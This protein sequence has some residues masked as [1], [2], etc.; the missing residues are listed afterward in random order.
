[1]DRRRRGILYSRPTLARTAATSAER[2]VPEI[3]RVRSTTSKP[4]NSAWGSI[5]HSSYHALQ[6]KFR[7]RYGGGLQFLVAY[8]WSKAIDDV[9]SVA[10]SWATRIPATRTT[11]GAIS[12]G[13]FR[14]STSRT[15]WR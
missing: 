4:L 14:R 12:T 15:C 6:T 10:G 13:R 1:M 8:T 2:A 5:A 7:K 11:T 9:S 3:E